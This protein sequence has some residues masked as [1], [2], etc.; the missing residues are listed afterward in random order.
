MRIEEP[1]GTEIWTPSSG[2]ETDSIQLE[3]IELGLEEG[4]GIAQPIRKCEQNK[5]KRIWLVKCK[6]QIQN[7]LFAEA[8]ILKK[9]VGS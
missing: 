2:E 5:V 3:A 1:H 4:V 9:I 6:L 8:I 7:A